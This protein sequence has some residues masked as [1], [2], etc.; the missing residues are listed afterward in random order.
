LLVGLAILLLAAAAAAHR[1]LAVQQVQ[2]LEVA[3]VTVRHL[4]LRVRRLL[5]QV[6]AEEAEIVAAV[7]VVVGVEVR[8]GHT[9]AVRR[10]L[11]TRAAVVVE[12]VAAA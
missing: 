8:A 11:L 2:M 3:E 6:V 1:L 7:Q 10:E 5:A 4:Q 12:E 9:L